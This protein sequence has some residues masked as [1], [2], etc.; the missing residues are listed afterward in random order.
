MFAPIP[1]APYPGRFHGTPPIIPN[2]SDYPIS[3]TLLDMEL[4]G[5]TPY[6]RPAMPYDP[7]VTN[8]APSAYPRLPPIPFG[9]MAFPAPRAAQPHGT[10]P[11]VPDMRSYPAP[12]TILDMIMGLGGQMPE[13][14]QQTGPAGWPYQRPAMSFE[15]MAALAPAGPP[16]QGPIQL[17]PVAAPALAIPWL[18]GQIPAW[19]PGVAAILGLAPILSGD[20][21]NDQDCDNLLHNVDI[22]TCRAVTKRRGAAA[23]QRS[24]ASA[25]A[26]YA[27]CRRGD[28]LPPLD[29]WDN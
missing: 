5:R 23:G 4:G 20:T 21:P 11:F 15:S 22:P 25:M 10:P 7:R 13:S 8:A 18:V 19:L 16:N 2:K 28:P 17:Q 24:Y 3:L 12:P 29:T 26:R 9:P 27:A 1:L 14:N 6:Q